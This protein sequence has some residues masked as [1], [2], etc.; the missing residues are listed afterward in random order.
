MS[1]NYGQQ[2][3]PPNQPQP[4]VPQYP[5]Q[6]DPNAAANYNYPSPAGNYPPAA[7][8]DYPGKTLGIVGLVFAF[9]FPLAG[10]IISAIAGKQSKAVGMPNTPAKVGLILSII[11]TIIGVVFIIIYIIAIVAI[12]NSGYTIDGRY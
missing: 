5:A 11:F 6:P 12:V 7:G 2:P 10:W 4:G 9:V 8:G 1:E 3:V